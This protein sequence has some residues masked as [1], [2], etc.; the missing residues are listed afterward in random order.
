M[1][2]KAFVIVGHRHWGK[3]FTLNAI[4]NGNVHQRRVVLAS[5]TVFL[6][7]MSQ[8]DRPA[9]FHDFCD[10]VHPSSRPF[11]I[12]TLCPVQDAKT[13]QSLKKL[14]NKYRLFFFVLLRQ[15]RDNGTISRTELAFL[16]TWGSVTV[17][18]KA[19]AESATRANALKQMVL[20]H[21]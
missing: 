4:S 16:R 10:R 8:D 18:S 13:V 1:T 14:A 5:K 3:S 12:M 2:G 15:Y 20:S 11:V 9:S 21:L 6:R 17:F 19:N 7:R